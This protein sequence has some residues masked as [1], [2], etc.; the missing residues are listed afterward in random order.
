VGP[1]G[2]FDLTP[3]THLCW[4]PPTPPDGPALSVASFPSTHAHLDAD[5]V[6]PPTRITRPPVTVRTASKTLARSRKATG[7]WGCPDGIIPILKTFSC[8]HLGNSN[9]LGAVLPGWCPSLGVYA[10]RTT[11]FDHRAP[12]PLLFMR[13]GETE[14][15]GP[16]ARC[17]EGP[18]CRREDSW[19]CRQSVPNNGNWSFVGSPRACARVFLE[20]VIKPIARNSSPM[21]KHHRRFAHCR[22]NPRQCIHRHW[23]HVP[24]F[25][26]ALFLVLRTPVSE[27]GASRHRNGRTPARVSP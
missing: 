19:L 8:T 5:N 17:G 21:G 7:M 24:L 23:D 12:P 3:R 25:H 14:P 10:S 6:S 22:R 15:L 26:R 2:K 13:A 20:R 16:S 9:P 11:Y 27:M 1:I 18:P 4:V